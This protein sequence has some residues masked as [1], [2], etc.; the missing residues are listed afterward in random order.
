MTRF[1]S[2]LVTFGLS[3]YGNRLLP[4]NICR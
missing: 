3:A 2:D 1:N 4:V